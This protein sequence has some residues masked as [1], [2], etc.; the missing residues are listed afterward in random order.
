MINHLP[1]TA[2]DIKPVKI[3]TRG[4][5]AVMAMVELAKADEKNPLPLADIAKNAGISLSYLEQLIAGMR[6]H[7]LV[8]SY[9][10][11]GG[12][13]VLGRSPEDIIIADI[14]IAAE[15]STPAK[16]TAAGTA[17]TK[18]CPQTQSLWAHISAILGVAMARISLKDVLDSNLGNQPQ[19]SKII[20][21]IAKTA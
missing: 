19:T 16:R 21:I 8:R 3:N 6:R 9:R 17:K 14:L 10:G 20:E 18:T 5:Y 1:N 4:Q 7:G 13:Y 12:G 11:P 2:K 15:D